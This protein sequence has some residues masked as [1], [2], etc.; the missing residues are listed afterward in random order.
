MAAMTL[1]TRR[2]RVAGEL[3]V[4]GDKSISHRSLLLAALATGRCT[5]RGVLTSGDTESSARVLRALGVAISPLG[6]VTIVDG[7]GLRGLLH[8]AGTLDCG[9]SGTTAR[10]LLGILAAHPFNSTLSGDASLS[11]RPMRRVTEPLRTMGALIESPVTRD[12]LPLTI[13]GGPL[14]PLEWTTPVASAQIKSAILLA[15]LC[16]GVPVTVTEAQRSRDHTERILA[17]LGIAVPS[18]RAAD[19]VNRV[20][21]TPGDALPAFDITVPGDPSSAA[22]FAALGAMA[23]VG[24]ITLRNIAL[25]PTRTGFIAVLRR[26]GAEIGL[27]QREA[28]GEPIG[29]LTARPS[30]GLV[31]TTIAEREVPALIDEIPV[32]A[33]VA[34][35]AEGETTIR[36]A[37]ELRVKESDRIAAV[38]LNLRAVGV[39]TEELADGMRVIGAPAARL[40][41]RVRSFGD[42]RIAMAFA[43]LGAASGGEIEIDDPSCVAISYPDFW[44]DLAHVTSG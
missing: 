38:V 17:S 12:G 31:G 27:D 16:G 19:G 40:Q 10:L 3:Q 42:H 7:R 18:A 26:M 24:E 4:L 6:P 33:C 14:R 2:L 43:T 21:L 8:A 23:G 34:A 11:Q 1:G 20:S 44:R 29:D 9:N 32:I 35:R 30:A 5:V 41:G 28:F 37:G 25:N 39:E 13:T 15:G 36:G 22:Y